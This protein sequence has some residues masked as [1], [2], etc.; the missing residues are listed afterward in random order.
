MVEEDCYRDIDGEDEAG[1]DGEGIAGFSTEGGL[2][3]TLAAAECGGET[4]A[5]G[6]LEE[7]DADEEERNHDEDGDGCADRPSG[8]IKV[9][10]DGVHEALSESRL[11]GTRAEV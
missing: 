4:A 1:E 11:T 7:D 3:G 5:L 8:K 6:A 10:E 9:C 2:T